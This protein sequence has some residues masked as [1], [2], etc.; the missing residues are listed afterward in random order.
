MGCYVLLQASTKVQFCVTR[1]LSFSSDSTLYDRGAFPFPGPVLEM[2]QTYTVLPVLKGL[3]FLA[4]HPY[5]RYR[6]TVLNPR[7]TLVGHQRPP[8]VE[9]AATLRQGKG[10]SPVQKMVLRIMRSWCEK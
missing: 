2:K 1:D 6:A 3:A 8:L 7:A 10:F 9:A 4:L 5:G